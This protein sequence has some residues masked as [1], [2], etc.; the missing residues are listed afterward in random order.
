MLLLRVGDTSNMPTREYY[1]ES[2]AEIEKIPEDAPTG[3]IVLILTES[4]LVVKMKNSEAK[5]IQI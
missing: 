2:E 4:G 3:S 1:V 5:W